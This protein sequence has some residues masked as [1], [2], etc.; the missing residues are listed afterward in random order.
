MNRRLAPALALILPLVGLAASWATTHR[1]AQ[2][3]T[4]WLVPIAG[5]D[6][7]DLLRGHY[8]IFTYDWPGLERQERDL[9]TEP[10]LCLEGRAPQ[11][12]R[13]RVPGRA[14][15]TQTVR[16]AGGWNDPEGGLARGRL[17]VSQDC[18]A[19]LQRQLA[20]PERQGM[21]RIRVREDGHLTPLG[22]TFRPRAEV[23]AP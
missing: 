22:I 16:A 21:V 5:Y 7:R 20:D 8:V 1:A 18:A 11:L 2:Q 12:T 4:E 19:T 10:V 15:C 17:Y 14:P 9:R 3:G 23:P 13:V 6:P